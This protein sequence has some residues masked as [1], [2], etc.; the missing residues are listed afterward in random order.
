MIVR[1]CLAF[2]S[3]LIAA[4]IGLSA[5]PGV[6]MAQDE[7]PIVL[8][9]RVI[10]GDT[11]PEINL[12]EVEILTLEM[13]RTKRAQ[14]RL[15]KLVKNVKAVYPYAKLAGIKLSYYEDQLLAA[16]NDRE[17]RRIMKK[18]EE[19]IKEEYGDELKNLTFSQG[20]I[21]I[22]LLDRE[23]GNTSYVLVQELRGNFTAFWYQAFARIWGYDLKIDYDPDGE[24]KQIETIVKMIER[25]QI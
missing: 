8:K 19:E 20:K 12:R 23:T 6:V 14:K 17:R 13:P 22:K 1:N 16:P 15:T 5:F 7:R 9:A 10:G 3:L 4:V 11:L 25:G 18:A 2:K 24:D 21:L